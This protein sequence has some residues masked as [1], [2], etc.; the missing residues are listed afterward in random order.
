M[1]NPFYQHLFIAFLL[2][3]ASSHAAILKISPN[4]ATRK[5]ATEVDGNYSTTHLYVN[6]VAGD[7]IPITIFFDPEIMGVESAEVFTNLNRRDRAQLDADGD[8]IEDGIKPPP[9]N[10]I[11]AGNEANYYKAHPMSLVSGGYQV[12][13][14]AQKTGAYRLTARYRLNGDAPGTYRYYM[15]PFGELC[16]RA[17]ALVISPKAARDIQLYEVNPLTVISTGTLPSQRGTFADLANGVGGGPR[18]NLQ[19]V[20]DLGANMLWFQPIHPNG[21]SGRQIDP[22][23]S[24]PFEVGSPYAVKNFFEVMPL[25]AKAF[26]PGGTPATNDTPAGRAQALAEFQS[27]AAA[28]DT[29]NVGVMLDAPFN[30]TS[31]DTEL[32]ALGQTFFGNGGTSATSEMRNTEARFFARSGAYDMRASGAGNIA[33]APDRIAEFAFADTYEVFFG[34]YAALVSGS[35]SGHLSEADWF[36]YSIGSENTAGDGHFDGI[37]QKVWRYFSEYTLYWLTQTGYPANVAGASLDSN[38]GIDS[39]RADFGQGL[40]PQCWEYIINKTRT[41]KWNFIFMA[42]SLDGGAVTYRSGRHFDILNENIVFPL[43]AAQNTNDYRNI[44]DARRNAYGQALVLLNSSSHDEDHYQDPFHAVVRY[45]ANSSIDG[46]PLIFPGQELGLSGAVVPPG[47]TQIGIT[48]FG[49]DRYEVNFGKPI[50]HFKKYNS[51]MPLWLKTQTGHPSFNYGLAQLSAVYS[52]IGQARK[53]SPALRSSN[54][55]FLNL[56]DTTPHGQIFSVAKYEAKNAAPNLSDTVLCFV[57]LDRNADPLTIGANKFNVDIDTDANGVNDFGIKPARQ[58]NVKN[59]A[60]YLGTDPNRRNVFLI[61]GNISGSDL[62]SQGLYVAMNKVPVADGNWAT[63]PYEA[64]YLK[65]YDVTP[66]PVLAAPSPG[67]ALFG[68][69]IGNQVTFSWSAASDPEGGVSGYHVQIG[70][71]PGGSDLL[72]ASP[73]TTS[74]SVTVSYG[75]TLYARVQQINNAG[76]AGPYSSASA[77]VIA[78]DPVADNDGDGQTNASEHTAGTNPLSAA[79]VLRATATAISGNDVNITVA[80]V[81]GKNYQLETSTT[82]APLSWGNVGVPVTAAGSSTVFTHTNGAGDPKRF[83]RARVVP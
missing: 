33:L 11:P 20:K 77:A 69:V 18:F 22:D 1:K 4:S 68:T 15:D 55:Y 12:T 73:V 81:S 29:E 31:Y 74:Q 27:F 80:T 8:T 54:R 61:P 59:I 30:H 6:E 23:T 79:S 44:Y 42:E 82:L 56:K 66:P 53:F 28:A 25:M 49:Y 60:A 63:A 43:H 21:I 32:A 72:D 83:Y 3:I 47:D 78:L 10:N 41:R 75:T 14:Q 40:P 57:N 34:R 70:T 51:L 36:D 26:T 62:I 65:L 2:G 58:Y 46:V 76:I 24:Q 37:T 50:P 64:Q 39:L 38:V 16:F 67:L 7:S 71:T 48:P 5:V 45:A 17:H 35:T 9:G 19:Y 52:G 13:L